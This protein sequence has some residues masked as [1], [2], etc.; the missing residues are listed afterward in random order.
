MAFD[1]CNLPLQDHELIACGNWKK[2]SINA[3]AI[4]EDS[5]LIGVLG[6]PADWNAAIAA[7]DVK[8]VKQ[9]KGEMP[10]PSVIEGS[11]PV[12]GGRENITDGYSYTLEIQDYN[13]STN[14]DTFY[15]SLNNRVTQLAFYLPKSNEVMYVVDEVTFN[16]RPVVPMS[17]TEKQHYLITASWDA[18]ASEFPLRSAAPAGIFT[19]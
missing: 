10:E 1:Y 15:E 7:G 3:F 8:I 16:A 4:I 5:T 14:N 2:G 18:S 12:G 13:V 9:V 17:S 19:V 6:D 11:N